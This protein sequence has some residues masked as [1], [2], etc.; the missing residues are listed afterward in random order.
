MW[1]F[2]SSWVTSDIMKAV[3]K[4]FIDKNG[5]IFQGNTTSVEE[6]IKA[7]QNPESYKHLIV[8]VGGYSARFVNLR[9]DLQD[10]IIQRMRHCC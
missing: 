5:Q 9:E 7:K 10:E 1:D 3:L 6:L 4:T 8:R 2:D